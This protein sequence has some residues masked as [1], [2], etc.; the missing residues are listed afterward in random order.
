[1]QVC[2]FHGQ[3]EAQDLQEV[4]CGPKEQRLDAFERATVRID[5]KRYTGSAKFLAIEHI[6]WSYDIDKCESTN[7]VGYTSASVHS[8][9]TVRCPEQIIVDHGTSSSTDKYLATFPALTVS[10]RTLLA[11]A[12]VYRP[13]L[14]GT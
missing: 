1:M 3:V 5:A 11:C 7:L 9:R 2:L 8:K 12:H 4:S 13:Q 10:E 14:N 6:C